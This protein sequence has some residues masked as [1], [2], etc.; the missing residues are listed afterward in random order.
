MYT[1]E[2]LDR[3]EKINYDIAFSEYRKIFDESPQVY[4]VTYNVLAQKYEMCFKDKKENV[5]FLIHN[6]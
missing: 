2:I 6:G 5:F 1:H 3:F 4:G